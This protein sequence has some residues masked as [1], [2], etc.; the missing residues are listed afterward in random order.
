MKKFLMVF[1]VAMFIVA[2]GYSQS[3]TV[4]N[5]HG[6]EN[7]VIGN[8]YTITW[9][10]SGISGTVGIKLFKNGSSLGYI[11]MDVPN[12]GSYSWTI[13]SIIGV[14]PISAGTHYQ[15]Q[16]KKSGVAAGLS[17]EFTISNPPS[18]ASIT[19]TNPHGGEV[20]CKGH[21]YTITW[22]SSGIT[23]PV[24]IKLFQNGSSLGY[25]A[26]NVSNTGHYSWTIGNIIGVGPI[27][28]GSH[29]QIQVKKSGVA[30]GLSGEFRIKS[31][32]S[33]SSG[34]HINP[35]IIEKIRLARPIFGWG[36]WGP[37]G[38]EGPGPL[39]PQCIRL[40]VSRI[41]EIATPPETVLKRGEQTVPIQIFLFQGNELLTEVGEITPDG[42]LRL[43][44]RFSTRN[45]NMM[46]INVGKE[47]NLSGGE[48]KLV[49]KNAETGKIINSVP[50]SIRNRKRLR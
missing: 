17:G 12:T 2:M 4:T 43:N 26:Q 18:S 19:V 23:G 5:P 30:A 15:I 33:G 8:T 14:G 41:R 24:G 11:A 6:G 48:L 44:G 36:P 22:N 31:S 47:I 10:S 42:K 37:I 50:I 49:F 13:S 32:C 38:P 1:L 39:C 45:R 7:W 46:I 3:I 34:P 35:W 25:V 27:S 40:D 29:Y 28:A 21:T 16:V 9:N 20:W